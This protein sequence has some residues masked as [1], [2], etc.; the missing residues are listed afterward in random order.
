MGGFPVSDAGRIRRPH[1]KTRLRTAVNLP[2][3][4]FLPATLQAIA[5]IGGPDAHFRAEICGWLPGWH[6]DATHPV[7]AGGRAES[8]PFPDPSNVCRGRPVAR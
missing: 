7:S 6:D 3:G 4:M 8:A 2:F 1:P 5:G